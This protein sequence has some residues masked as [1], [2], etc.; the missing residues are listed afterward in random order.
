MKTKKLFTVFAIGILT[1]FL[2]SCASEPDSQTSAD[3]K[4]KSSTS[5]QGGDLV[6][7]T[8]SDVVSLDPV[9]VSDVPSYDVQSNIFEKLVAL[10]ED[11]ELEPGLATSWESID[12]TTWEFNLQ[13][14]VT[15]HD[16]TSFNAG[17]VKANVERIIDP[18]VASP[19]AHHF[20]MIEDIEVVD[21]TTVRFKTEYPFAALPE[22]FSHNV[23]SM[24]SKKQIEEDYAAMEEGEEPGSVINE[25]P[26]G[27][28]YFKFD[29]WVSGEYVRVVNNEDYWNGEALLDSVTFKVVSEDL[30]RMA[31][32][33]TGDSHISNPVSPSDLD[34]IE[35][36][37]DDLHLDRQNSVALQYLGF[38][39]QK[40]P[41]DDVRVRQAISMAIDKTQIMEGIYNN[42][43]QIENGML[44]ATMPGYD[45]SVKGIDY[46]MDQ[47]KELLK[48]AG[49]P[50]GF[51]TTIW[52]NEDRER[53][54]VAT[55]VQAQLKE[56]GIESDIE[57][58]EWGT[59][60][61]RLTLGEHDLYLLG[62]SNGTGTADS[63]FYPNF[64]S[65]NIGESGNRVFMD[66][67]DLDAL[68]EA[69]RQ[70]MDDEERDE[71]YSDIQRELV[72]LAPIVPLFQPEF[73]LGVRNEVKGLIHLPTKML[74][75]KDVYIEE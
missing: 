21:D 70:E 2:A 57:I 68:I 50:D 54:D 61:D 65:A 45:A 32:L 20:E 66:D 42:I 63:V 7:A 25:N 37:E 28:G 24:V 74:Y 3:S 11:M 26:I 71:I 41:F 46:D 58:M 19:A 17:V 12:D 23:S 52:L 27:T 51:S 15:F 1:V 75:L 9:G 8:I 72:D 30:T 31:E 48:E 64:H 10:N 16:G 38:N 22:H 73:I 35:M 43:G 18:D 5:N 69:G 55:N 67:E 40:E 4:V 29:E 13:E 14:G 44:P 39:T 34:Q 47:A 33:E 59:F 62:W 56:I 36:N 6:V 60:L 49:Y 53:M